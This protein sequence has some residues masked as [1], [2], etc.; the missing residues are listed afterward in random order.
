MQPVFK[1]IWDA[2]YREKTLIKPSQVFADN[3]SIA[4]SSTLRLTQERILARDEEFIRNYTSTIT[5]INNSSMLNNM[6][7]EEGTNTRSLR[8]REHMDKLSEYV[9]NI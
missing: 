3:T 1:S 8:H 6:G 7:A 2:K 5:T 4:Q 9:S